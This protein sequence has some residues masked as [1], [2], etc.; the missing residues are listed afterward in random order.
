MAQ[1]SRSRLIARAAV[2]ADIAQAAYELTR[3]RG[4]QNVTVDDMAAA[5]GV[6]RSTLLRY[7]GSKEEVVLSAFDSHAAHFAEA[8]RTRPAEEDDW[9]A[10]R[11]ALDGVAEFYLQ[12]PDEALTFTQLIMDTPELLGR[13]LETQHSWRPALTMALAERAGL[14]TEQAP[15]DMAVKAAAAVGC[16]IIAVE[17]WAASDGT[18]DLTA[19]LDEGFDALTS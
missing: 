16:L 6:S 5:A 10:L 9:T 13:H 11:R 14:A 8:L 17:R 4:F 2:R 1:P 3:A 18:L 7:F 12:D 19:L 15:L